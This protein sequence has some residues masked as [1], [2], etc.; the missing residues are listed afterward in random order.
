MAFL[1]IARAARM[2]LDA[3]AIRGG[4]T[5]TKSL[6]QVRC[7]CIRHWLK[8]TEHSATRERSTGSA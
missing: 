7:G 6:F 3:P 4:A 1:L 8:L 2:A 5:V